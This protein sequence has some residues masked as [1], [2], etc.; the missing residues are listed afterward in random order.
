[1][2]IIKL[3]DSNYNNLQSLTIDYKVQK[4]DSV[5]IPYQ[6]NIRSDEI[7]IRNFDNHIWK[8][9]TDIVS[10]LNKNSLSFFPYLRNGKMYRTSEDD[11]VILSNK[12]VEGDSLNTCINDFTDLFSGYFISFDKLGKSYDLTSPNGKYTDGKYPVYAGYFIISKSKPDMYVFM[13]GI[14]IKMK[15]IAVEQDKWIAQFPEYLFKYKDNYISLDYMQIKNPEEG[16]KIFAHKE[17]DKLDEQFTLDGLGNYK[18]II[19]NSNIINLKDYVVSKID[20]KNY[21]YRAV[22]IT[23]L[24]DN[25]EEIRITEL[26]DKNKNFNIKYKY[27]IDDKDEYEFKDKN[28]KTSGEMYEDITLLTYNKII[29]KTD[30]PTDRFINYQIFPTYE[31][32]E[33]NNEQ[34]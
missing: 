15:V 23:D 30:M 21:V 4:I 6:A 14:P 22:I 20:L 12:I 10:E 26:E 9:T 29:V 11:Y 3:K 25:R 5:D 27:V 18:N 34:N 2:A 13:R 33:E 32:I 31:K 16:V 7:D 19:C 1:M 28:G 17:T 8:K 24:H